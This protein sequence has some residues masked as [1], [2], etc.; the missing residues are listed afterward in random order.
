MNIT[1]GADPELFVRKDG[2]PFSAHGLIPGTK[3]APH[4]VDKGAVQVDGMALEFNI[5][6]A[7]DADQFVSNVTTVLSMLASMVPDYTLDVSPSM[8]FS[9]E[10]MGTQPPE[11]LELGCEPDFN[12]YHAG[13][14]ESPEAHPTMR[15]AGGHVHV[16]FIEGADITNEGYLEACRTLVRQLDVY[17]GLPSVILDDNKERR[18]MYGKA[19]SFRPKNYGL[20]YRVLS[21]FWIRSP[22][23][24]RWVFN[25][26]RKAAQ[27]LK[28]GL[29]LAAEYP[30]L[31]ANIINLSDSTLAEDLIDRIDAEWGLN[32]LE[33]LE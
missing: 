13:I 28:K 16:G 10:V 29:N 31:V 24:T 8:H 21:N 15:V 17:L 9:Q 14:N 1:I 32:L 23:L 26:T 30:N 11:A 4:V 5:D 18:L 22:E 6:P 19:G 2:L 20:E 27:D 3:K 7:P 25:N 12:A 33:G